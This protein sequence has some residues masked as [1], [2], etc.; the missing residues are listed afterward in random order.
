MG[1]FNSP[2]PIEFSLTKLKVLIDNSLLKFYSKKKNQD[3]NTSEF[4][5]PSFT[6]ISVTNFPL[7]ISRFAKNADV[8]SLF[9]VFYLFFPP[10]IMFSIVLMDIVKEK[11]NNLKQFLHLNGLSV[12]SYW[13]S[14][15]ITSLLASFLLATEIVLLGK[16]IFKYDFFVNSNFLIS[17]SL[18]FFFSLT[19]QF[20]CFV[21]SGMVNSLRVATTV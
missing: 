11:E 9:G 3:F 1:K 17:F 8:I 20:F 16:F 6:N 5:F 2:L 15:I 21:I 14:W 10:M 7:P 4:E 18:F 12:I 13:I 19:M